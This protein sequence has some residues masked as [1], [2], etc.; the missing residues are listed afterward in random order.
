MFEGVCAKV[1]RILNSVK[2]KES[3]AEPFIFN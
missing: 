3:K 1:R 2:N